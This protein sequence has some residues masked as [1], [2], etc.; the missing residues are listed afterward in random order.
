VE[1]YLRYHAGRVRG[2][3]YDEYPRSGNAG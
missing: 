2:Y 3:V 1:G